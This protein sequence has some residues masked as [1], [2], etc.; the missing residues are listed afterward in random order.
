MFTRELPNKPNTIKK[1]SYKNFDEEAFLRDIQEIDFMDVINSNDID[2]AAMLFD[3][4]FNSAL[5][6]HAPIRTFQQHKHYL[7]FLS[8]NTKSM[9]S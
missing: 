5:D 9:M 3:Q 7:P 1:R 6:K 8:D 4:K 2:E